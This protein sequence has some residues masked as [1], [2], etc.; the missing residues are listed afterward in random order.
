MGARLFTLW[1]PLALCKDD[2]EGD[3]GEGAL[4]TKVPLVLFLMIRL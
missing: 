2:D 1:S 4:G 3:T